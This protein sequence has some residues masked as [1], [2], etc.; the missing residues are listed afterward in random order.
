MANITVYE[1]QFL[2]ETR[3]LLETKPEEVLKWLGGPKN[4]VAGEA[5][6][7]LALSALVEAA[8]TKLTVIQL[9]SEIAKYVAETR[10]I[11]Q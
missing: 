11:K 6:I 4:V 2:K 8:K 1:A 3:R 10:S 5:L 9:S 7:A